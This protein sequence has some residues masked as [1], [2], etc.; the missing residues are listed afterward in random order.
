MSIYPNSEITILNNQLVIPDY[1]VNPQGATYINN[2]NNRSI[3]L[4]SL[5]DVNKIDIL[6]FGKPFLSSAYL[7]MDNHHR[8]FSFWQGRAMTDANLVAVR[9]T[10][11][12]PT[13]PTSTATPT[14]A[15]PV[16]P[17]IIP[18]PA[19]CTVVPKDTITDG[20]VGGLAII[21]LCFVAFYVLA[22][23]RQQ[24]S[25]ALEGEEYVARIKEWKRESD[26]SYDKPEMPS[27][28]KPMQ[29]MPL[30]RV[31]A[32][33]LALCEILA[34]GIIGEHY[35]RCHLDRIGLKHCTRCL[36]RRGEGTPLTRQLPISSRLH[37]CLGT[38]L[39]PA[40]LTQD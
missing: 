21:G 14:P 7:V 17:A 13:S 4:L 23:R 10:T 34:N 33:A 24:H 3:L 39:A 16:V 18:S 32:Y 1:H 5:Q 20:A 15:P 22:R 9:P 26:N 37:I 40:S 38:G 6:R 12:S 28:R 36:E 30:I 19:G 2:T 31:P 11:C 27:D 29:E 8:Q 35:M 25:Q